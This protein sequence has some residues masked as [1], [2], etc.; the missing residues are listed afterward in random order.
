MLPFIKKF[1][2]CGLAGWCLEIL[3]TAF[4]SLKRKDITLKGTTSVWMF[5]IYGCAA[6][7]TPLCHLLKNMPVLFRGLTYMSC[8]F[9]VEYFSGTLLKKI[10]S[11]PW[12]YSRSRWNIGRVIRLDFA[13]L[14]FFTGLLF[15]KLVLPKQSKTSSS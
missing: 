3:F 10:K 15:E 5:P 6:F 11:C 4:G 13:P 7:L 14:W 1:L 8:I 2:K 12:D 9:T